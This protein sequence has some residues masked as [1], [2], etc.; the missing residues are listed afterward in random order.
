[1]RTLLTC[2]ILLFFASIC[3]NVFA[4]AGDLD[5]SFSADGKVT[6]NF[7]TI[8]SPVESD[9]ATMLIQ[10][11][12][13]IV[14]AGNI[15]SGNGPSEIGLVRYFSD[16]TLDTHFGQSGKTLWH[17]RTYNTS[18]VAMLLQGTKIL[19]GGYYQT[20]NSFV[21]LLARFTSTGAIDTTFGSNGIRTFSAFPAM[22]AMTLQA[23]GKIVVAGSLAGASNIALARFDSE[24][25]LDT[26]F[27]SGGIADIDLPMDQEQANAIK[28]QT[29][30]KIVVGGI[31][32][33]SSGIDFLAVR[34]N[35][36]GSLDSTFGSGGYATVNQGQLDEALGMALQTDGKIVLAGYTYTPYIA[37]NFLIVRLNSN[38]SLDTSFAGGKIVLDFM[39]WYDDAYDVVVQG[40]G[41]IVAAGSASDFNGTYFALARL[42]SDGSM[43]SSFGSSG[44]VTTSVVGDLDYAARVAIQSD[45][46]IVAA[47]FALI[48]YSYYSFAL[49]R[50]LN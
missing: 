26:S 48:K 11:N 34:Y 8:I 32:V 25:T 33:V 23:D 39:G 18:V 35:M 22:T 27:G 47:G 31:S 5:L 7:G 50:Y 13:R 2:G 3:C 37:D 1:M 9:L 10:P 20:S 12:G 29:D 24:G 40:D 14:A 17:F 4:G 45:G 28:I 30:G 44:K 49:A 38:G 42:N 15:Y 46:K 21:M 16:G 43:D 6:T 19:V 41:K 36:D